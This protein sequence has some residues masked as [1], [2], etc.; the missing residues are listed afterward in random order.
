MASMFL[1]VGA[2]FYSLSHAC[3]DQ[4]E[5]KG[6]MTDMKT[7]MNEKLYREMKIVGENAVLAESTF[8]SFT[9]KFDDLFERA[10]TRKGNIAAASNISE[11]TL[12]RLRN[13]KSYI[14]SLQTVVATCVGMGLTF[15]ES[16]LLIELSP[17]RLRHTKFQDAVYT[18]ILHRNRSMGID[19]INIC[20]EALEC[21]KLGNVL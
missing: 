5:R 10:S 4:A 16:M 9:T 7:L 19:E 3:H 6:R 21:K 14:P 11:K 8:G 17:H 20:L 13:D 15:S 1:H 18:H 2:F 12:W